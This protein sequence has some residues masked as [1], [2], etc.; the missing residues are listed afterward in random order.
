M[1]FRSESYQLWHPELLPSKEQI[2]Q[3]TGVP[4][5]GEV[6]RFTHRLT[7]LMASKLAHSL[8]AGL[9]FFRTSR[10]RLQTK[11]R[12]GFSLDSTTTIQR[13]HAFIPAQQTQARSPFGVGVLLIQD[14]RRDLHHRRSSYS[15]LHSVHAEFMLLAFI[16]STRRSLRVLSLLVL[17]RIM[18]STCPSEHVPSLPTH[19]LVLHPESAFSKDRKSTRLNSSHWE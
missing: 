11:R 7:C 19:V 16:P 8:I 5:N 15:L 14:G 17:R 4:R 10:F 3:I 12:R 6:Q 9:L 18:V 1:L 2:N 13:N